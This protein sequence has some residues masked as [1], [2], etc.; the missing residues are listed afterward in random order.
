MVSFGYLLGPA[1]TEIKMVMCN[2]E[3]LMSVWP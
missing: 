1:D 3:Q 2:H